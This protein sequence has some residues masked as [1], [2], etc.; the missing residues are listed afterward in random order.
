M[1]EKDKY[2]LEIDRLIKAGALHEDLGRVCH[3]QWSINDEGTDAG[4][5]LF[6]YCTPHRGP[7]DNPDGHRCGCLTQIRDQDNGSEERVYSAWTDELTERIIADER[8]PKH[9]WEITSREQLEVFAEYQREMD[10]TIR[11]GV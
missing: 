5:P 2:E 11:A 4:S 9:P 10:Q 7:D 3:E 8:L 1:A 6:S